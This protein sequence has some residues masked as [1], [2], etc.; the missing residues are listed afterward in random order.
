MEVRLVS[1]PEEFAALRPAWD[2]LHRGNIHRSPFLLH[3]WF[4]AAWQWRSQ[5]SKLRIFCCMRGNDLVGVF[6]LLCEITPTGTEHRR[7]LEFLAVPDTQVCDILANEGDRLCV[8][9]ALADELARRQREWDVIKLRYLPDGAFALTELRHALS[10]NGLRCN[11]QQGP[12]NPWIAL[13][14]SWDSYYA[15]RSRRLKK[16]LNLAANR[17]SR[18]GRIELH[19]L[20]PGQ[21]SV[22]DVD[23]LIDQIIAI[24]AR[25]WKSSTGNSLNNPGPKAFIS[26]LT[27]NAHR[28][29]LL[30]IWTLTLNGLPIAM[31]FQLIHEQCV[32]ALRSD[33]DAASDSLSPGSYLSRCILE[34]L[35]EDDLRT[36][37][38]G[39]GENPYKYRW[40][41]HAEPVRA[42]TIYGRTLHGRLLAARDLVLKPAVQRIQRAISSRTR[43]ASGTAS[44]TNQ[45]DAS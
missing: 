21:G 7:T 10:L 38:M 36:Y 43:P 31:E 25:S 22:A 13:N 20:Q 16:A 27:H 3:E 15:L 11:V 5:S 35:F 40:A 44:A 1:Q 42:M 18:A 14:S 34:R 41:D 19:W 23:L 37:F 12:P 8:A 9:S 28:M 32:F 29:E 17:L 33:F 26:R 45:G 24:S 39:P 4:D 6:P 2:Q 30:S